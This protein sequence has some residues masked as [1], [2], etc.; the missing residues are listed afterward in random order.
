MEDKKF[1]E[2]SYDELAEFLLE[3]PEMAK[4]VIDEINNFDKLH[5]A[6]SG[7]FIDTT[8]PINKNIDNIEHNQK[9]QNVLSAITKYEYSNDRQSSKKK[10]L[11]SEKKEE[12]R[13]ELSDYISLGYPPDKLEDYCTKRG[14][15]LNEVYNTKELVEIYSDYGITY[16]PEEGSLNAPWFSETRYFTPSL[17]QEKET[18]LSA[19]ETELSALEDESQILDEAEKQVEK[20]NPNIGDR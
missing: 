8:L 19:L 18:K 12:L 3:N 5:A 2:M 4:E 10:E 16:D 1:T 11:T 9:V 20:E 6:I 13:D 15:N 17:H 7:M 14:Y